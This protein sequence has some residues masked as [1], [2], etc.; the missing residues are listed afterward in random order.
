ML[1]HRHVSQPL[2]HNRPLLLRPVRLLLPGMSGYQLLLGFVS[3]ASVGSHLPA[4]AD[5]AMAATLQSH[6]PHHPENL[7][8]LSPPPLCSAKT[9]LYY[10]KALKWTFNRS[11]QSRK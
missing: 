3:W 8:C 9:L 2:H 6:L 10:S 4:K 1:L 5:L 7:H 11:A